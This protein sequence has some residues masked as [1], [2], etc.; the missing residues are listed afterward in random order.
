V[1][2]GR[3]KLIVWYE[4]EVD[5]KDALDAVELYDLEKDIGEQHNLARSTPDKARALYQKFMHWQHTVGAQPM[6]RNPNYN[7]ALP[8]TERKR[9]NRLDLRSVVKSGSARHDRRGW[10]RPDT[11]SRGRQ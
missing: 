11:D 8:T 1:A 5:A 6:R 10:G 9:L 4:K 2:A 7:P 3:Y